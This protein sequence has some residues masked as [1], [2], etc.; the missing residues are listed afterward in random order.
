VLAIAV[1]PAAQGRGAGALLVE[2]FLS[3][4]RQRGQGAAHVVVAAGNDR[5]IALYQ[6][7]GFHPVE[8]F[9]LHEG[10]ESLLM[11]WEAGPGM[12]P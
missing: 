3:E 2:G 8:R 9:A 10:A 4:I 1:D 12:R 5:A 11:Q 7:A 6:R